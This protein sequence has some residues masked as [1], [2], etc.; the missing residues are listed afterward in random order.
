MFPDVGDMK[1]LFLEME[2]IMTNISQVLGTSIHE[3]S[4]VAR[5]IPPGLCLVLL[6]LGRGDRESGCNQPKPLQLQ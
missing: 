1:K 3:Q 4:Q 6:L 5:Y 2:T